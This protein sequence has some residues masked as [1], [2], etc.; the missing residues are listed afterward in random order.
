M[1]RSP[2]LLVAL[3]A[4]CAPD[5]TDLATGPT[6]G[7]MLSPGTC[8]FSVTRTSPDTL[9]A[10]ANTTD[11]VGG[12]WFLLK[13]SSAGVTLLSQT[14]SGGGQVTAVNPTTW[15]N[16]PQA[17]PAQPQTIDADMFYNTGSAGTGSIGMS[18]KYKCSDGT[19]TL[20]KTFKQMGGF[21]I[22]VQ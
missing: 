12:S 17:L 9:V 10:S 5:G 13:T 22:D 21:T 20:T 14:L 18:L 15:T 19:D 6:D 11:N 2:L 1:R 3:L 4:A 8:S 7:P 16:F